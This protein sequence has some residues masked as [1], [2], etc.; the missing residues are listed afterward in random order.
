MRTLSRALTFAVDAHASFG[1]WHAIWEGCLMVFTM[2]LDA[3]SSELAQPIAERHLLSG[4]K[5]QSAY[6]S[7]PASHTGHP[8]EHVTVGPFQ[9][10]CGTLPPDS[11]ILTP[12][13]QSKLIGLARNRLYSPL[14]CAHRRPT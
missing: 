3:R 5:N 7:Q 14:P 11:Y 6:I 10:R 9:I 12:S 1:L 13:I 8:D 2:T 4:V